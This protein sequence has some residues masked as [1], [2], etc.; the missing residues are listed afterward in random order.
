[1]EIPEESN[2]S[3]APANAS[4]FLANPFDADRNGDR[5]NKGISVFRRAG[6]ASPRFSKPTGPFQ[7]DQ[8]DAHAD[9][10]ELTGDNL[11]AAFGI[12]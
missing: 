5:S 12:R 2:C 6:S 7:V 8:L 11:A 9:A 10:R 3:Y 4:A 1:M